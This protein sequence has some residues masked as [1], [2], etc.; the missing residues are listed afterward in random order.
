MPNELLAICCVIVKNNAL[1]MRADQ[2]VSNK[3]VPGLPDYQTLADFRL[4]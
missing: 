2:P 1:A 3:I 4:G